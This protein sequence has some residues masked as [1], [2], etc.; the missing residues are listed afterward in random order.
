MSHQLGSFQPAIQAL[1]DGASIDAAQAI[2]VATYASCLRTSSP[3]SSHRH[4]SSHPSLFGNAI[5]IEASAELPG[6]G[7]P[8]PTL[9]VARCSAVR[10]GNL[11]NGCRPLVSPRL[12]IHIAVLAF[13]CW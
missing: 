2:A 6:F 11:W 8:P 5:I 7:T 12:A 4:P 9:P 13:N 10:A 3:I 1:W